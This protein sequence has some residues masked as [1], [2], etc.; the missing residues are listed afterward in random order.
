MTF[1]QT[2]TLYHLNDDDTYEARTYEN[3]SVHRRCAAAVGPGGFIYDN[4]AVVRI[5]GDFSLAADI[6]DYVFVGK[7]QNAA[8]DKEKCLVVL[9]VTDNRRGSSYMRHWRLDCK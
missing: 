8:P 2:V 4:V 6:G 1:N 9:G 7:S 5:L 3:A